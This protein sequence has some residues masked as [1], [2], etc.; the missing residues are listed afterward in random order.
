MRFL[1]EVE[2]GNTETELRCYVPDH[3][4]LK[5]IKP[6]K[7]KEVCNAGS[8]F[9]SVSLIDNFIG[10]PDLLRTPIGIIFRFKEKLIA[11][12]ADVE[13]MFPRIKV[14]LRI[15]KYS[16]FCGTKMTINPFYCTSMKD[17]LLGPRVR[18]LLSVYA[19]QQVG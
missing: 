3:P 6:D 4:V 1:D 5:L 11:L 9:G 14:P 18:K 7:V 13:T 2:L 15:A 17:I 19:L 10:G 8:K 12:T 16:T